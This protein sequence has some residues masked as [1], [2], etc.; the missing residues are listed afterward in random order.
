MRSEV[1][2][3]ITHSGSF[4]ADDVL[5]Y[6]I[7]SALFPAAA[8]VRTRDD[9]LLSTA[10]PADIVFDVG[11]VFDPVRRRYDHHQPDHLCRVDGTPY[12]SVG[13]VWKFHG[14]DFVASVC[15]D[16][17]PD[18]LE[19]TWRA[20]DER[21]LYDVDRFDNGVTFGDEALPKSAGYFSNLVEDFVPNWDDTDR[22]LDAAFG[23]AAMF[24]TDIIVAKTRRM[25]SRY[26]AEARVAEAFE[27]SEDPRVV[28]IPDSMPVGNVM[29]SHGFVEA[30][31]LVERNASNGDWFVN[32]VRP[33]G[34]AFGM[35]KPLPEEWAGLRGAD[36]AA[37][38]GVEDAIFCHRGRFTCGA[39]SLP[40]AMILARLAVEHAPAVADDKDFANAM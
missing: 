6:S 36:L 16:V 3:L 34:E 19:R 22:D 2:R 21:F 40:S 20:I 15:R 27:N 32:C 12:S 33:E 39:K 30:L 26:K 38:T 11:F 13:L 9:D 23:R 28:V 24:A 14:R 7:L 1:S 29:H 35:R 17:D 18:V 8:L 4:H 31:Y 5:A 10:G 25:A 37:V